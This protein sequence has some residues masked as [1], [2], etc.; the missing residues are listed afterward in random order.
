MDKLFSEYRIQISRFLSVYLNKKGSERN[1]INPWVKDVTGR[2]NR[3]SA[4][5]KMLRGSLVMLS[6]EMF[7]GSDR[8]NA[9]IAASALELF[10]TAV[11]V[12]DDII[13]RDGIRRGLPTIHE[14][15]KKII[16]G[17][18]ADEIIH[19]GNSMAVCAGDAGYFLLYELFRK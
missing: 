17:K 7:E 13:D 11:L 6:H 1:G 10:Q 16:R 19:F 4:G 2:L 15:Y 9:V 5:G 14:Q 8:K 12:H 18:P 3:L